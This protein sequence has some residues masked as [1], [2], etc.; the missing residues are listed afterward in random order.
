M[1]SS[2]RNNHS[3]LKR[4]RECLVNPQIVKS[5][6]NFLT[7]GSPKRVLFY[8]NSDWQDFPRETVLL[9]GGDFVNKQSISEIDFEGKKYFLDFVHT[10]CV[11]QETSLK[12]PLAW[13]DEN[14]KH[15]FPQITLENCDNYGLDPNG[16][17]E[18]SAYSSNS[19]PKSVKDE[20]VISKNKRVKTEN[21]PSFEK[22]V[23]RDAFK[24]M[25]LGS[26]GT[27]FEE[28]DI[29]EITKMPLEKE[30][31]EQEI[32]NVK[33]LRGNANVKYAYFA[34]SKEAILE[35]SSGASLQISKPE[36]CP[37]FG[38]GAH[39]FPSNS[40]FDCVKNAEMDKEG[41]I[42]MILCRV[43]LGKT[44]P[45]ILNSKQF[46]PSNDDYDSGVDDVQ[47][48]NYYVIWDTDLETRVLPLIVISI[49]VPSKAK[50][51]MG[52]KE[53][54]SD[55]LDIITNSDSPQSVLEERKFHEGAGLISAANNNKNGINNNI[56]APTSPWMP[57]SMLF[58][59]ISTKVSS[60]AMDCINSHYDD[61]KRKKI[62]RLEL[63]KR[64]REIVGDKLLVSTIL[65]LQ[66]KLPPGAQVGV[67]GQN[68]ALNSLMMHS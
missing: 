25:L 34:A 45:L 44:E 9:V 7:S 5:Y 67:N 21:L 41:I 8:E 10:V 3:S 63:V 13:I 60:H 48:P 43:I 61:Y 54:K 62:S 57:F 11:D 26:L 42:R 2:V 16:S 68:G 38:I 14:D 20:E 64:L 23:S 59:S 39:L 29:V 50:E 17:S 24:N 51:W 28:K 33:N 12:K 4:K 66:H 56:N 6:R 58:A 65:R 35:I 18:S 19:E 40:A 46:Q 36:K 15:Y 55:D 22:K 31:F 32:E 53:N 27:L 47:S 49:K 1:N 30:R 52:V 37:S